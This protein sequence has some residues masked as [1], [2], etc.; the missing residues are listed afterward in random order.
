MFTFLLSV[1]FF[2]MIRRPPRSTRTDTL[3]P[4]TTLFRSTVPP[5]LT[6]SGAAA[7]LAR[8]P[9]PIG[10]SFASTPK[11][12]VLEASAQSP[13]IFHPAR[14]VARRRGPQPVAGPGGRRGRNRDQRHQLQPLHERPDE[15]RHHPRPQGAGGHRRARRGRPYR[16]C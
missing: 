4:Y 15:G 10:R 14:G 12:L 6:S 8:P 9:C 3:F 5:D 1:L 13:R 7:M 2:L 11:A 16:A